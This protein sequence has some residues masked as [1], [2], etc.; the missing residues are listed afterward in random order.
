ME[1]SQDN[2]ALD[3][4]TNPNNVQVHKSDVCSKITLVVTT[5][6]SRASLENTLRRNLET[7]WGEIVIVDSMSND[8]TEEYVIS[9]MRD[10]LDL[11]RYFRV[12]KDGLGKAR[13][14]GTALS[15]GEFLLHAGPDNFIPLTAIEAMLESLKENDLV[16]CSTAVNE[17]RNYLD[18]CLSLWRKRISAGPTEVV[19]TPFLG[20][21]DFLLNHPFS[22]TAVHS[23]DTQL[24]HELK[25]EGFRLYRVETPCLEFG[26]RSLDDTVT[27]W[28][29]YGKS[30]AEY[31]AVMSRGWSLRRKIRS[32]A[33]PFAAEI[34][35]TRKALALVEWLFALPFFIIITVSRYTGWVLF[36]LKQHGKSNRK[37]EI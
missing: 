1:P 8:G 29:G 16:T 22:E 26:R 37:I 17:P 25:A 30:D 33:H 31:Y 2:A 19:G 32:L 35:S 9:V 18:R 15:S 7:G 27:R 24:S 5:L 21:R 23:D 3:N 36:A 13:N 34:I 10:S 14:I 12:P 4:T 6:N 28:V 20:A 11:L